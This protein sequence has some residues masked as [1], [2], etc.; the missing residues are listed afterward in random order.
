MTKLKKKDLN[1]INWKEKCDMA[2]LDYIPHSE[3]VIV[4]HPELFNDALFIRDY[5]ESH[6]AGIDIFIICQGFIYGTELKNMGK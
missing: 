4:F 1:K 6:Y 3:D 5:M 2:V